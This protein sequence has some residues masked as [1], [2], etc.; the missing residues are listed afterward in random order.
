MKNPD[1]V[2]ERRFGRGIR[3]AKRS[4]ELYWIEKPE[5]AFTDPQ[6]REQK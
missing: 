5:L 2:I 4:G 3:K 1:K 6:R